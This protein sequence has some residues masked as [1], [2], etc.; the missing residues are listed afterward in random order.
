MI[1]VAV[2]DKTLWGRLGGQA[3]ECRVGGGTIISSRWKNCGACS[4]RQKVRGPTPPPG[5][6]PPLCDLAI[7]NCTSRRIQ[8][9]WW[10]LQAATCAVADEAFAQGIL[11]VPSGNRHQLSVVAQC[12]NLS[13]W[14][15]SVSLFQCS[16]L[17][18][19]SIPAS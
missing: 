13:I 9:E 14:N 6:E 4:H 18:Q 11:G 2:L 16:L 17:V 7:L 10:I 3:L 19:L 8:A 5:L 1:S 12:I 15:S